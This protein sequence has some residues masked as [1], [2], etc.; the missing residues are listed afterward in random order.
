[1][2]FS[3]RW[4]ADTKASNTGNTQVTK[5]ANDMYMLK[6]IVTIPIMH[7][8]QATVYNSARQCTRLTTRVSS[9]R[10]PILA[11]SLNTERLKN[12][13]NNNIIDNNN[14]NT[15]RSRGNYV[16]S[17]VEHC[18]WDFTNLSASPQSQKASNTKNVLLKRR[19]WEKTDAICP[20]PIMQCKCVMAIWKGSATR[21]LDSNLIKP[22][23]RRPKM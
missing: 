9:L 21:C 23:K 19:I 5:N 11:L 8:R 3:S 1:M 2:Q 6:E 14:N 7:H 10:Y 15:E 22:S 4:L 12:Y 13:N 18:I 16:A 17:L 20:T